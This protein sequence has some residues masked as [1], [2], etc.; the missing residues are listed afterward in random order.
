MSLDSDIKTSKEEAKRKFERLVDNWQ[1]ANAW[2]FYNQVGPDLRSYITTDKMG[3]AML[4]EIRF[5]GANNLK[6]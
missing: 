2:E 3:A 4:K 1:Y 5:H 6:T